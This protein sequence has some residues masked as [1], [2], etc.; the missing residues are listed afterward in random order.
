MLF[1]SNPEEYSY[2]DSQN[3]WVGG[4]AYNYIINAAQA[5]AFFVLFAAFFLAFILIRIG[6]KL[7]SVDKPAAN[8]NFENKYDTL[9]K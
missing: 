2:R 7:Q 8:I 6:L 3:A 5:T 1:Y 9:D 4:D